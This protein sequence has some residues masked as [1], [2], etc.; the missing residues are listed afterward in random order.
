MT[1]KAAQFPNQNKVREA[2]MLCLVW[3]ALQNASFDKYHM[4]IHINLAL[5]IFFGRI[6]VPL[7]NQKRIG[8][9]KASVNQAQLVASFEVEHTTVLRMN[10]CIGIQT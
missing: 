8:E 2:N 7:L 3:L 1:N 6:S 5:D 9:S 4:T 10:E